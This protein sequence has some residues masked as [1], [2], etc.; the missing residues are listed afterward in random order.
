MPQAVLGGVLVVHGLITTMIG[1]GGVTNPNGPAMTLPSWFSWWP[2][3]FGRSWL[4]E[5]LHLGTGASVLGGLVWLVAGVTL[6]AAGLGW[7]GVPGVRDLWQTLAFVGAAVG[8]LA[9][10]VYFHPLYL[11][12]VAI[13]LAVVVLLWGRL[14]TATA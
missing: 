6:V 14:T 5:A 2:G 11:V 13:D 9:L 10:A 3:P 4:F 7:L 1:V 8:L 12:A